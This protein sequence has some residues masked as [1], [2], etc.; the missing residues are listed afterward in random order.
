MRSDGRKDHHV[1]FTVRASWDYVSGGIGETPLQRV[2]HPPEDEE[3][4]VDEEL[5]LP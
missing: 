2:Y 3:V 5:P 1:G 4:P